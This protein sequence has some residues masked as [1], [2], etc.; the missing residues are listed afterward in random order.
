MPRAKFPRESEHILFVT[1]VIHHCDARHTIKGPQ[2]LD[3]PASRRYQHNGF[4]A[5]PGGVCGFQLVHKPCVSQ[6]FR[7]GLSMNSAIRLMLV[8]VAVAA[9]AVPVVAQQADHQ[10]APNP[11]VQLL[12]S[13]GILTA[14]EAATIHTASTTGEAN[15]RLARL[16]W[17][18]GLI[19]Q[20]EY[21]ATVAASPVSA[22]TNGTSG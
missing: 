17:S 8:M 16:L 15:E 19:S 18:K 13:K 21:N 3:F 22:S 9:L 12:Q 20:D 11:L 7:G 10:T 14:E 1:H 5:Y 6:I 4:T 2:T